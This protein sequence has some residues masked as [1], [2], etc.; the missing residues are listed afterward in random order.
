MME[1]SAIGCDS[2]VVISPLKGLFF[3]IANI[4]MD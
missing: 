1:G 2:S 3:S 4:L